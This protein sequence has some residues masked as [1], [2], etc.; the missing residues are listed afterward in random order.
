MTEA[1]K[2]VAKLKGLREFLLDECDRRDKAVES[3]VEKRENAR[4]RLEDLDAVLLS[5][6]GGDPATGEMP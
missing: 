6:A 3:A 1:E 5:L 2:R 4:D